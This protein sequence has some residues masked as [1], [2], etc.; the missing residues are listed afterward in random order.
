MSMNVLI[1]T[2]DAV[3]STL[4]Q[5][6]ITIY[7]Q[8][9]EFD[10]PVIN[11]HELTNGLEKY[12]SP[13]F[14]CEIVSKSR[15]QTWG[16]YQSLQQVAELLASVDHYKTS[17]LAQ[18]H[19]KN[20]QDSI[21]QQI[22]FYQYLDRNFFVIACRRHNVFEHALSMVIN[23]ITKKLNVFNH[24]EKIDAFLD[25]C[26]N[27]ITI[28]TKV[29]LWQLYQYRDY[30]SWSTDYFN[31]S[32]FFYY[33]EHLQDLERYILEL[34]IW[35]AGKP[36]VSWQD[37]FGISWND[38]N[39]CHH[40]PSDL[41]NFSNL[42]DVKKFFTAQ[43]ISITQETVAS[44]HKHAQPDWPFVNSIEDYKSLPRTIEG[45][46]NQK[47]FEPTYRQLAPMLP[48]AAVEFFEKCAPAYQN[49]QIAI[50]KMKDL[51]IIVGGPPIKKQTLAEKLLM[52]SNADQCMDLYNEWALRNPQVATP[53]E[54][55]YVDDQIENETMFWQ[56]FKFPDTASHV[57]S[58]SDWLEYQND[59]NL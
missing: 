25:M 4:L 21:D 6:L 54:Q 35:P 31:V 14:G 43:N 58:P 11:L 42:H 18:Y 49:A 57:R 32:S 44:Y 51:D 46:I 41:A 12:Y 55:K 28:D 1:L 53:I 13:E 10:R 17:R 30:V 33:D 26:I 19:M 22:P 36:R 9:H 38:W 3:G 27:P 47:S 52:I 59:D 15:V 20:R 29:F 37:K 40:I 39:R 5:R 8:F 34:P 2:P 7:M 56:S 50:K 23:S 24:I 48:R 16:Y 45:P